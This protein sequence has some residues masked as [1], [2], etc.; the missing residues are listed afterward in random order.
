[1]S[2]SV[3]I[4]PKLPIRRCPGQVSV[5]LRSSG[6]CLFTSCPLLPSRAP[7]FLYQMKSGRLH[8]YFYQQTA[9]RSRTIINFTIIKRR[10]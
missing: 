8:W 5:L 6:S 2:Y 7:P 3:Q 1:M 9:A 4:M 10:I